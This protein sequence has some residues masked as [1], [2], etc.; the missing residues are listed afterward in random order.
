MLNFSPVKIMK[1]KAVIGGIIALI[2]II[3][4]GFFCF[5]VGKKINDDIRGKQKETVEKPIPEDTRRR[6]LPQKILTNQ[7]ARQV[8]LAL[9]NPSAAENSILSANNYLMINKSFVISYNNGRG[10]ANW[11]AWRIT[12]DDLGDVNRRNNFRPDLRLPKGFE[13]IKP[14]DYTRSGYDRGHFCP[15]ADRTSSPEANSDTF[16]MTN[17]VPQTPDLNRNA[18][19]NLESYSRRLVRRTDLDLFIFAGVYGEKGKVKRKISV[20]TNVWKI[21]IGIP[22]GMDISAVDEKSLIIAA[23]FPNNVNLPE[24]DWRKYRTTIRTIE[25]K[26]GY[27]FLTALPQNLQDKL[28]TKIDR[29]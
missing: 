18:W 15:S 17:V 2:L 3:L 25:Q 23:D 29:K 11:A 20:P 10:T 12:D 1:N 19:E 14:T 24:N 13:R 22:K 28:E 5:W 4:L 16:L 26:T 6:T 8:Y 9:G 21:I 27:N 7:E